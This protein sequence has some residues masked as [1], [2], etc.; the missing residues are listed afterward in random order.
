MIGHNTQ[1]DVEFPFGPP[2]TQI[3]HGK[4]AGAQTMPKKAAALDTRSCQLTHHNPNTGN[5]TDS[6]L[7]MAGSGDALAPAGA[8][9][10]STNS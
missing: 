1:C 8:I 2:A 7:V 9:G 5:I 10:K 4:S 3:E 6:P